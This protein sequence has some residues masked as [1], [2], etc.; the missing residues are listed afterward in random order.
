MRPLSKVHTRAIRRNSPASLLIAAAILLI[1]VASSAVHA[2]PDEKVFTQM[3]DVR[4][5]LHRRPDFPAPRLGL[6]GVDSS[7]T[8]DLSDGASWTMEELVELIRDSISADLEIADA[9]ISAIGSI[10]VISLPARSQERVSAIFRGL[11]DSGRAAFAIEARMLDV[12]DAT[13]AELG[14]R[15]LRSTHRAKT[16]RLSAGQ[17]EEL[18]AFL[19]TRKGIKLVCAPRLSLFAHQRTNFVVVDQAAYVDRFEIGP[20]G[21]ATQPVVEVMNTGLTFEAR[22]LPRRG[23]PGVI[24]DWDVKV[25]LALPIELESDESGESELAVPEVVTVSR[26]GRNVLGE[27]EFLLVRGIPNPAG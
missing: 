25:A 1:S 12:D 5:L 13:V 4:D 22:V 20:T 23:K 9:K 6:G 10:L 14:L 27:G 8:D 18:L 19:E 16:R 26:E 15:T 3:Y 2:A 7:D 21:E 24:I 11:R 17:G